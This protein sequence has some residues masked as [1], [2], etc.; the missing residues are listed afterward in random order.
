M[1]QWITSAVARSH[2]ADAFDSLYRLPDQA[3]LLERDATAAETEVLSHLKRYSLPVTDSSAL[4]W[5]ASL[6]LDIFTSIAWRHAA[7]DKIPEKH[8]TAATAARSA[9]KRIAS[10]DLTLAGASVAES[11]SG[12][13]ASLVIA[14]NPP[15]FA[16]P[17]MGEF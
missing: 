17:S 10:G 5:L 3:A 4:A 11:S 8:E 13:A 16:R 12:A 6:A 1:A 15:Q 2:L 7:G 14:G 9:L